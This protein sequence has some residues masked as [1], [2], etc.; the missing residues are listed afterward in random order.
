[1]SNFLFFNVKHSIRSYTVLV[2]IPAVNIAPPVAHSIL[3]PTYNKPFSN[4]DIFSVI[5]LMMLIYID[6][7]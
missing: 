1:M 7:T 3:S 4:H 5:I 2:N 6:R